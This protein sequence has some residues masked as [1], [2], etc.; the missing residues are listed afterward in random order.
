M[1][2][3]FCAHFASGL[4]AGCFWPGPTVV[5]GAKGGGKGPRE[6]KQPR[7]GEAGC[8]LASVGLGRESVGPCERLK[9]RGNVKSDTETGVS[10]LNSI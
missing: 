10:L 1:A 9:S 7:R 2:L 5:V 3:L 6:G 8:L 4:R